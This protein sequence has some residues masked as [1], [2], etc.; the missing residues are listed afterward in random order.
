MRKTT[1]GIL[2]VLVSTSVLVLA[3]NAQLVHCPTLPDTEWSR[4]YGGINR[5][6]SSSVVQTADGGYAMAGATVPF[7]ES[8][9]ASWLVKTDAAGNLQWNKTYR[10]ADFSEAWSLIQ[11]SDGGYAIAGDTGLYTSDGLRIDFELVKTDSIGNLIWNKTYGGVGWDRARSLVQTSD[12]GFALAGQVSSF[13]AGSD[14][15]WLVKTDLH[16]NLQWNKTYGGSG[17]DIAYSLVQTSD[18]GYALTGMTESFS[19]DSEFWLARV[20]PAGNMLWNKTYGGPEDDIARKIIRASDGGYALTGMTFSYGVGRDDFW[21]VKTDSAGNIQWNRT[22]GGADWDAADSIIQTNDGGYV[23]AGDTDSLGAG[24]YDFWLIRTDALGNMLWNKT[25]GGIDIEFASSM[26]ETSDGGC[27][28]T[29]STKSFGAGDYD[30]WLIKLAPEEILATIDI[31]P[32]TLNL[33]SN[34]QWITAYIELPREHSPAEIDV[35]SILLNGSIGVDP[36]APTEIGDHD[37]DGLPD[38]MVKFQRAA[39]V[40]WLGSVDYGEDTGKSLEVTLAITGEVA[41]TPFEGIGTIR[42]LLKG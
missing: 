21:L 23:I 28:I 2:L 26:V 15:F 36:E 27:V 42:V 29:G 35:A 17:R 4:T 18:G 19:S 13:G 7:G 38:L 11:T 34:G 9:A 14:D 32:E 6:V 5:D 1:T 24:S 37:M 31:D 20:D 41:G 39:I 16:G 25:C 22:Y 40:E 30:F 10:A 33:K 8:K 3:L 12:G